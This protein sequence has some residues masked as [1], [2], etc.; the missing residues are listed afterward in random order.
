MGWGFHRALIRF[1]TPAHPGIAEYFLKPNRS[2]RALVFGNTGFTLIELLVVIAIIAVLAALLLPAFK[3]MATSSQGAVCANNLQQISVLTGIYATD[4]DDQ[5]PPAWT[6]IATWLDILI[7][8]TQ[9]GGSLTKARTMM[10]APNSI[11]RCPVR[12]RTDAQYSAQFAANNGMYRAG[13]K[14]WYSYAI[15]YGVVSPLPSVGAWPVPKRRVAIKK[16]SACIY[17][18]DGDTEAGQSPWLLNLGWSG[19]YPS[20]RHNGR[21]NVLWVDGH[22][23]AES[24]EGLKN[25]ANSSD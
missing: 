13:D 4:H 21:C 3:S 5:F 12:L 17:V 23:T 14:W 22:V 9:A 24:L 1:S 6:P 18:T 15:N 20:M 11:T 19:A 25:P 2:Y 8:E 10:S 16:P 7:A